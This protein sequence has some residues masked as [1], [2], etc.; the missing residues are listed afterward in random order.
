LVYTQ[1]REDEVEDEEEDLR[2]EGGELLDYMYV[3]NR[4]LC[5]SFGSSSRIHC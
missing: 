3:L 4:D 2:S 5:V 1:G